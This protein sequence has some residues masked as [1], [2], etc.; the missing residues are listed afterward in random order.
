M[1]FDVVLLTGSQGSGKGTQGKILAEKLDFFFWEMG[2]IL[3]EIRRGDTL[4]G[5][6]IAVMD[7]GTLL[8]DEVII[9][10]VKNKFAVIPE[11]RGIIFDGIPRRKIGRAHV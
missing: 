6:K 10:I 3:R 7:K 2:A 11:V 9:D 1:D 4:L 5:K 8:A